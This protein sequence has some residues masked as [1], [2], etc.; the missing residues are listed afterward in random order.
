MK[1][2]FPGMDPYLEQFWPDIHASLIIYSRDQLE[3]QLPPSLIARVE[4]RV[5]FET[6]PDPHAVY[7]DVKI[8]ERRGRGNGPATAVLTKPSVAE[9]VIVEYDG[10]PATE[11]YINILEAGPEQRL[12]TVIEMLSLSNKLPGE[13]QRQYRQK[14][15]ELRDS[16]VSLVEID[17]LRRGERVLSIAPSRIPPRAR[18]TYQ[19]CVRRGW[20]PRR[21]EIY[22]V[23]LRDP[24]PSIR[25]PLREKDEDIRLD[26]QAI[27]EQAYRKGRY[28]LTVEYARPPEPP[29]EMAHARWA[30]SVIKKARRKGSEQE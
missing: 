17:L 3:E 29:L 13:G 24:L 4:E 10:E 9:P 22:P 2:P 7:P 28:Y 19:I 14:Q 1:S 26:L 21:F 23:P 12:V 15:K 18:T 8:A 20:L 11:T 6:E 30:R 16:G 27:L 25:I 5:V